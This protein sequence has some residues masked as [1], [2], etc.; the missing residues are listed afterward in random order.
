[1]SNNASTRRLASR[2]SDTSP[3]NRPPILHQNFVRPETSEARSRKSKEI[4]STQ[5]RFIQ[6]T[7]ELERK[8]LLTEHSASL[9]KS[10]I[11]EEN[12]EVINTM[13]SYVNDAFNEKTLSSKLVK[14]AEK[15]SPYIVRPTSPLPKKDELIK[16]VNTLVRRRL[17]DDNDLLLLNKLIL[18]GD[19]LVYSTFEVFEADRDEED[20]LDTLIR[21]VHKYKKLGK[22]DGNN[23]YATTFYSAHKIPLVENDQELFKERKENHRKEER[24][25]S[26]GGSYFD[27]NSRSRSAKKVVEKVSEKSVERIP[28]P[29]ERPAPQVQPQTVQPVSQPVT[30]LDKNQLV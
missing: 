13:N 5:E 20:L 10:L 9:I 8:G 7:A 2:E 30:Q 14:L 17:K 22:F 27:R 12:S 26:R 1:M 28:E 6:I 25:I 3:I 18:E 16:L 15:L 19:E 24:P 4:S 29:K 21:I 23:L 11:L